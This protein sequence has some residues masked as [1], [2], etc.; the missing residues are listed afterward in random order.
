[1]GRWTGKSAA[2]FP[3]VGT[4]DPETMILSADTPKSAVCWKSRQMAN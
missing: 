4:E 3:A 1:M 2:R